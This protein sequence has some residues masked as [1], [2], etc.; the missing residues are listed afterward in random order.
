[1]IAMATYRAEPALVEEDRMI[2]RELTRRGH[3]IEA[4]VWDADTDWSP[5]SA[6]VL[7]SCWDYDAKTEAF[8]GWL[9]H[10]ESLD[11]LVLNTVE[12]VRDNLD[13]RYLEKLNA[14]GVHCLPS[15]Y[16]E[17]G[18][19]VHLDALMVSTG[20]DDVVVKP[21]ISLSAHHT[22]RVLG[23][24][25]L[26]TQ[27]WFDRLL[28]TRPLIVQRFDHRILTVGETSF[29]FIDDEF[30]HA[31]QKSPAPG[32]FLVQSEFG[33][34]K[35]PVVPSE[36]AVDRARWTLREAAHGRPTVYG[37]VDAILADDDLTVMEVELVDPSLYLSFYPH[38]ASLFADAVTKAVSA[39]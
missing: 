32:D 8:R 16:L 27:V 21:A 29:V 3:S 14:S 11:L 6:V 38:A 10:L 33:G 39:S 15:V 37:R 9:D 19:S 7:R 26:A 13:K 35:V 22:R 23:A 12:V 34:V 24:P 2:V 25:S 5:Y 31:V 17:A 30:T 36:S 4:V 28:G 20:W 18:S 1:M